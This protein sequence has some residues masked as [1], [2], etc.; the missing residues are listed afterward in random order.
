MTMN[1]AFETT[2]KNLFDHASDAD[3]WSSLI[4]RLGLVDQGGL[5]GNR[6]LA[7]LKL[8]QICRS[9]PDAIPAV[10]CDPA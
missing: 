2:W 4:D 6:D 10:L 9:D 1:A 5:A 8:Y 3:Y 7:M